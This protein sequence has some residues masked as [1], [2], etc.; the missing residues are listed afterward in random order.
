MIRF[1][2]CDKALGEGE[3]EITSSVLK[4]LVCYVP[5]LYD[6]CDFSL[7]FFNVKVCCAIYMMVLL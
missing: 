3:T 2:L 6:T 4:L 5:V 7:L 1:L